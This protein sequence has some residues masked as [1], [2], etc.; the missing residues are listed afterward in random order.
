MINV[1]LELTTPDLSGQC[2]N[3]SATKDLKL[4]VYLSYL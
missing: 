1:G 4:S 3:H 2:A